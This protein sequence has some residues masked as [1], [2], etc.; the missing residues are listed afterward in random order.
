MEMKKI[1]IAEDDV[2]IAEMYSTKIESKGYKFIIASDGKE[3][4]D[5]I[6]K[7]N[8]DVILLDILMPKLDGWKV[9]ESI[10]KEIKDNSIIIMLTNVGD[11]ESVNKAKKMGADDY[12]IKSLHTPEEVVNKIEEQ[13]KNKK[14]S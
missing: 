9:L 2:F 13:I 7:E 12:L 6:R 14:S 4:L 3:A 11:D 5:K 8:P 10:S 1:L